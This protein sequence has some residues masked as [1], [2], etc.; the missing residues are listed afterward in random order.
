MSWRGR[1]ALHQVGH[2]LADHAAELVAVAGESGGDGDLRMGRVAVQDEVAVGAVGEEARLEHEGGSGPV[3]KVAPREGAEQLLVLRLGLAVHRV[4]IHLLPPVMVLA[5][6]EAG[7]EE[8]GEAVVA[9][10]LDLQ[11]EDGEGARQ[12]VL[13]P[14]RAGAM[15][16]PGAP[17]RRGR[18]SSGTSFEA[19][20]PA[21][22]TSRPAS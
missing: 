10:L 11:V 18:R 8:A 3:G 5:E 14:G 2:H 15:P 13:G 16:A 17:G 4:G 9:A 12:E 22:M 21:Q 7:D 6:L 19:Q 1:P 20:G